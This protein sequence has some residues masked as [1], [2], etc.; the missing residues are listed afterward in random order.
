MNWIDFIVLVLCAIALFRGFRRGL[1]QRLFPL[2]GLIVGLALSK[3]ASPL[4][5]TLLDRHV[6]LSPELLDVAAKAC[7]VMFFVLLGVVAGHL[8]RS[9][10]NKTPLSIVDKILGGTLSLGLMILSFSMLFSIT[11]ATLGVVQRDFRQGEPQAKKDIRTASRL[12][13]PIKGVFPLVVNLFYT[14]PITSTENAPSH[15][16]NV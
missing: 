12:Y 4:F 9:G 5:A 6:E 10:I 8:F 3:P 11:D 16:E 14:T 13:E 2:A 1:I 7:V 15:L